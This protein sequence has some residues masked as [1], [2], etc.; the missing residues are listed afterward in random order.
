[1]IPK[2]PALD[3]IRGGRRLADKNMC[4]SNRP[5]SLPAEPPSAGQPRIS[6]DVV[7]GAGRVCGG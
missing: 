3:L 7:G 6:P 2:K 1:M 4:H 5:D